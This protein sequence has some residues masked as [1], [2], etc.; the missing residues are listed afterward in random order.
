[1]DTVLP[2]GARSPPGE[3]LRSRP[4]ARGQR[5]RGRRPDSVAQ[6]SDGADLSGLPRT[7]SPRTPRWRSDSEELALPAPERRYRGKAGQ[8]LFVRA[9]F[10]RCWRAA[11]STSGLP[12]H[13]EPAALPRAE[14]VPAESSEGSAVDLQ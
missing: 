13:R 2:A 3:T 11:P 4:A 8:L 14:R 12:H 6:L 5:S 9:D 10:D 1:P 7:L